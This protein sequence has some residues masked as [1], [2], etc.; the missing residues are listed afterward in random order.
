MV[1]LTKERS[2]EI[3]SIITG[4][5]IRNDFNFPET[6]ITEVARALNIEIRTAKFTEEGVA[7]LVIYGDKKEKAKIFVNAEHKL[8]KQNFTIAHEIGHLLIHKPKVK[9]KYKIDRMDFERSDKE[10]VKEEV[11]AD[12]FAS[13]LLVPRHKLQEIVSKLKSPNWYVADFCSKYF[14]VPRGV[15]EYRLKWIHT[16]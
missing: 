15:I 1:I 13:Q 10:I 11:E 6:S 14:N 12:Y 9:K 2:N 8:P 4:L 16:K 3:S 7:G 5:N